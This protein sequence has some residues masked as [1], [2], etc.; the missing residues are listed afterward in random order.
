MLIF[1]IIIGILL[2]ILFVIVSYIILRQI[3]IKNGE[4]VRNAIE[5]ETSMLKN[6]TL[7]HDG[8]VFPETEKEVFLNEN[9]ELSDL[10]KE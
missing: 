10:I 3:I 5:K 2:S 7:S 6:A 9:S 4:N 1:G 8:I